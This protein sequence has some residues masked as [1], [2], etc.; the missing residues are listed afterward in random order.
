MPL[1][2]NKKLLKRFNKH[3]NISEGQLQ[4][5]HAMAR[6]DHAFFSGDEMY[7]TASVLDKGRKRMVVFNKVKPYVDSVAGFMIQLRRKPN[8]QSVNTDSI[9]Q[10]EFSEY[11]NGISDYVRQNGNF[12]QI[13]S[14]Q[15]KEMLITGYGAVDTNV[16]YS[17]NPDG[18]VREELINFNEVY[19]DPQSKEKNLLDSRWVFRRK[20]Y[21]IKEALKIF[22]GSDPG[23]FDRVHEQ[24]DNFHYNPDGG[25]YDKI[26]FGGAA[27]EEELVQVYYYQWWDLETY[28]RA[29]NPLYELDDSNLVT[30]LAQLMV[31]AKGIREE[32]T[33]NPDVNDYFEF[34]PLDEFLVMT[35]S[36]KR[37]ME[38]LF[39]R[40][41]ISLDY[42]EYLKK[43]YYTSV[44]SSKKVFKKF[45]SPHQQG[46]TIKFKTGDY[47]QNNRRWF[48]MVASLKEPSKYMNKSLTEI[49]YVIA[50]N[51][52]GGIMYEESAVEDPARF[53]QQYAQ[54]KSAIKVNDGAISGGK[55]FPKAQA[56]LPSGYENVYALSNNSMGE[57][58][59]INKEFL[60][61]AENKQVSALFESQRINQVVSALACYFD[62]IVLFQKEH[63]RMIVSFVKI[64]AENSEGRLIKII[65]TDGAARFEPLLQERL[66]A[67][68]D[69]DI[70]E[71]PASVSQKQETLEVMMAM[72][73]K[74]ALMGQNI[75]PIVIQYLPISASDKQKLIESLSPPPVD[76]AQV[77]QQ[78]E[79]ERQVKETLIAAQ[80][81][82]IAKDIA[83]AQLDSA[84]ADSKTFENQET[85]AKAENL[86]ADTVKTLVEAEQ[87][88]IENTAISQQGVSNVELVI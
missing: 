26:S 22:K 33:D 78:Q 82:S 31:S 35:P 85:M 9:E 74:L 32:Q 15:D 71:T 6:E 36:I 21:N 44:N 43:V 40:F 5:Q 58:S 29:R 34:D 62:S 61:S 7:Y 75:Y 39:D 18:E 73:D 86:Q 42:Q 2:N 25:E 87:K 81:A 23:D 37:D 77:A 41:G 70:T 53:E 68:Y 50:S 56:A 13:E 55:F 4:D 27:E 16:L 49:L 64:L 76:P 1:P 72:A 57:V 52:K 8:Y 11:M 60:G 67:E 69:V 83:K 46:F 88:D 48:G 38:A 59:G 47:D 17:E 3:K 24:D 79:E 80:Q 12:D 54:T 30:T 28:Y 66:A 51:S 84:N 10:Q 19:W 20:K 14:Q 63:A 45:K 65:G